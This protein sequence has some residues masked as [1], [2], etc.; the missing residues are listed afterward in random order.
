MEGGRP[1][2]AFLLAQGVNVVWTLILAYLLFGG[3]LFAVP[4][5]R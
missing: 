4:A 1:A 3:L 2:V 5:I